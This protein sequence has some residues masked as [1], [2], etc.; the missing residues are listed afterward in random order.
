MSYS[1]PHGVGVNA[2]RW[3][4]SRVRRQ[5]QVALDVSHWEI[6]LPIDLGP[7]MFAEP[8]ENRSGFLLK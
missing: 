3:A 6:S 2:T 1:F 7:D 5:V 4:A 8:A